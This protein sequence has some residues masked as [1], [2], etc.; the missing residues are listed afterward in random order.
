MKNTIFYFSGTG[1]S[2]SIA[3]RLADQLG[4]TELVPLA[5]ANQQPDIIARTEN[6][7]FVFPV[8]F[9]GLPEIVMNF[10][11]KINLERTSYIFA[12]LTCGGVVG[13]AINH[14]E[15]LLKA[16]SKTLN[17]GV[18]ITMPG[19]Y[20]IPSYYKYA[21]ADQE[22]QKV[23]FEKAN[24]EIDK[25]VQIIKERQNLLKKK[26]IAF[27]LITRLVNKLFFVF[28]GEVHLQDKKYHA[29]DTCNACG[30]C[31]KLCPVN[32][33]MLSEGK[34]HWQHNCQQCMACIQLCPQEAIQY[35]NQ[36]A[37]KPRYHHPDISLKDIIGQTVL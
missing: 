22:K 20:I 7:G 15:E 33:I 11:Q 13:Y 16:K 3:K 26:G 34:P 8:Y 17:V 4:E 36:T 5:K 9:W 35:G 30:T 32:N 21:Y 6:V 19:N 1:N 29:D 14:L 28:L 27:N 37:Q 2:L 24:E 23:L 25:I 18:R 10:V 12:V 31:E